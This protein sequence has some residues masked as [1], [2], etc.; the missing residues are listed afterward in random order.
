M[1]LIFIKTHKQ[2]QET[3]NVSGWILLLLPA[4]EIWGFLGFQGSFRLVFSGMRSRIWPSIALEWHRS[5][6]GS[7]AGAEL[8][9]PE[10][11]L[12]LYL[13]KIPCTGCSWTASTSR[14]QDCSWCGLC[15]SLGDPSDLQVPLGRA[16][17]PSSGA[18][19]APGDPTDPELGP[20]LKPGMSF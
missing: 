1:T 16:P 7:R 3:W 19:G 6:A 2:H 9:Q 10:N 20:R 17:C 13:A 18:L 4:E 11:C 12:G 15:P 14:D 8:A 5:C